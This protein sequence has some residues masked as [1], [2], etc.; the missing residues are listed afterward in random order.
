MYTKKFA[1]KITAEGNCQK[2]IAGGVSISGLKGNRGCYSLQ[3][4]LISKKCQQEVE[5]KTESEIVPDWHVF[6]S[7]LGKEIKEKLEKYSQS[8][9]CSSTITNLKI[10]FSTTKLYFK[11]LWHEVKRVDESETVLL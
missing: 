9:Y 11:N 7:I 4:R 1:K 2:I 5:R 10:S 6:V 8:G 3:H